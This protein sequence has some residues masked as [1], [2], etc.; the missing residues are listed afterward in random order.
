[1]NVVRGNYQPS[2]IGVPD[3][4]TTIYFNVGR[5][6]RFKKFIKAKKQAPRKQTADMITQFVGLAKGQGNIMEIIKLTSERTGRK[7]DEILNLIRGNYDNTQG[8]IKQLYEQKQ[9]ADRDLIE[10]Q[11]A[12]LNDIQQLN[13]RIEQSNQKINEISPELYQQRQDFTQQRRD[14]IETME[15][16]KQDINEQINQLKKIQTEE[17]QR[18]RDR[19]EEAYNRL[20]LDA[21]KN[22]DTINKNISGIDKRVKQINPELSRELETNRQ[23]L[24]QK[25]TDLQRIQDASKSQ[26][27]EINE[28]IKDIQTK[29]EQ[30]QQL[31]A[32]ISTQV[33][34]PER[35]TED[36][37]ELREKDTR[38]RFLLG[39]KQEQ[40]E[41]LKNIE[42]EIKTQQ[43]LTKQRGKR[44]R[45]K[46][47]P[48]AGETEEESRLTTLQRDKETIKERIKKITD[49][50]EQ[51]QGA[52]PRRTV[53]QMV[54]EI[55]AGGERP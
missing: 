55:E 8:I 15:T 39:Q 49:I 36:V 53:R 46:K 33:M 18:Q 6:Y 40:E 30:K 45:P 52:E 43:E 12:L 34:M 17:A 20:S 32:E 48:T 44:G 21:M 54:E 26:M 23:Q 13:T 9:Q 2:I 29:Q 35:E 50:I 11:G 37:R 3:K 7:Q 27:E 47:K 10:I 28:K 42:E 14:I 38:I 4:R 31:T 16:Q 24:S 51:E 25:I 1:M 41:A 5:G 22:F 19:L